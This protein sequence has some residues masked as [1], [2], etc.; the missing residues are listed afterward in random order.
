MQMI[1]DSQ[2]YKTFLSLDVWRRFSVSLSFEKKTFTTAIFCHQLS[3]VHVHLEC[4]ISIG[5]EC[6]F[7]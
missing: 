7:L 3:Q 1:N 6:V 5:N 4:D 2:I